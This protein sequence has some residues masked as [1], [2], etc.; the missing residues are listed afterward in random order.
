MKC[1]KCGKENL[2]GAQFCAMCGAPL[3]TSKE[4]KS[5]PQQ[6]PSSTSAGTVNFFN[7]MLG[8]FLTPS[9]T[10]K[11][12]KNNLDDI[13]NGMIFS[14][15]VAV[16]MMVVN[17]ISTM[18]S[19]VVVVKHDFFSDKV[20]RELEFDNIK[21]LPYF[22][23]IVKQLLIYAVI[24]LAV[25]GIFFIG[26]LIA[27]KTVT[28]MRT[29]TITA[30]AM[31]PFTVA[32]MFAATILGL[33][34]EPL[35]LIVAVAGVAYSIAIFVSLLNEE[36]TFVN[37]DYAIYYFAGCF[38]TTIV[39]AYYAITKWFASMISSGIQSMIK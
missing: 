38:T 11:E 31:I 37:K 34:W 19:C 23:L 29:L 39:I 5:M 20:T 10:Y 21:E 22:D 36:V 16:F 30:V 26:A 18:I 35:G 7:F 12:E 32:T 15:I 14:G 27:K 33:I 9:K 8:A 6:K 28:Y 4:Q 25:A 1:P 17:L 24:I 13:K 3:K 2:D